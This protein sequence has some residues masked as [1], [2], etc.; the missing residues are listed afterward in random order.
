MNPFDVD[1]EFQAKSGVEINTCPACGQLAKR[2]VDQCKPIGIVFVAPLDWIC[3]NPHCDVRTFRSR[4]RE[5]FPP[6]P[7]SVASLRH[8]LPGAGAEGKSG[9]GRVKP[10][11]K[12]IQPG[13]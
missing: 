2:R 1:A 5:E 10:A 12:K 4:V 13:Q 7:E 9:P 8:S 6:H 3:G 11:R